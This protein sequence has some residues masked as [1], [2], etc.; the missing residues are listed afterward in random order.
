VFEALQGEG[1]EANLVTYNIL[2]DIHAKKGAWERA[3]EVLDD[4]RSKVR[5]RGRVTVE[6][7]D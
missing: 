1:L 2:A 4:I 7:Q 6:Q 3:V 5:P